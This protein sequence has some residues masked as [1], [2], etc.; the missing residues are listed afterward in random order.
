MFVLKNKKIGGYRFKEKTFYSAHHLGVDYSAKENTPLYAPFDGKII[1]SMVGKQGGQTIWYKPDNQDVI[2]RLMHLNSKQVKGNYRE[3]AL[4]GLTGNT[5]S[6]T[7]AP[8]LH[9]DISKNKVVI[10]DI[11]NF[12]D[13]EKFNWET[14][15][16]TQPV[17]NYSVE[18]KNEPVIILNAQTL[19]DSTTSGITQ[20]EPISEPTEPYKSLLERIVDII[21]K[22]I[23]K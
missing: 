20:T 12:I 14:T 13:P 11:N 21:I 17:E 2:I 9:L 5:G 15:P 3:G 23:R 19:P 8:H 10:S 18:V 16:K 4:I 7:T 6:A 22:W 1:E